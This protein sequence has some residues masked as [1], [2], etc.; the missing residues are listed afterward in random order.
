[1]AI[2]SFWKIPD[3]SAIKTPLSVLREQGEALAEQTNGILLGYVD[4]TNASNNSILISMYIIVPT[5]NRYTIKLLSY[6]QPLAL[7]PGR[8]LDEVSNIAYDVSNEGEF[9]LVLKKIITSDKV[10]SIIS[11][12]L[13]QAMSAK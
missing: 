13:S 8:F 6:Y 4:T 12:L 11:S 5:M 10:V 2:E 1:M 3:I 7:Y 9:N